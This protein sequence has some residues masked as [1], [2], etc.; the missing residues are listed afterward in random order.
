MEGGA[1]TN[2]SFVTRSASLMTSL[3]RT[4]MC[5]LRSVLLRTAKDA[6]Q[7]GEGE[8]GR[9]SAV[10][11]HP[12]PLNPT[13]SFFSG[14]TTLSCT[15]LASTEWP[16]ASTLV[17]SRTLARISA[18]PTK[19][20]SLTGLG[21]KRGASGRGVW[22]VLPVE[23]ER[24]VL[25]WLEWEEEMAGSGERVRRGARKFGAKGSPDRRSKLQVI[26]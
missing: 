22:I 19:S 9:I 11:R 10:R 8:E 14:A 24:S 1:R 18:H 15:S 5:P 6:Q 13:H 25:A 16:S 4:E 2:R 21:R 17:L 23:M 26:S 3:S 7:D 20:P 12:Q